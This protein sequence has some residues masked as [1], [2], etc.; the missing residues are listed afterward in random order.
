MNK[1][2]FQTS[3]KVTIADFAILASQ[4]EDEPGTPSADIAPPPD[5]DNFVDLQD[6][7]VL[8]LSWMAVE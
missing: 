1:L 5:G 6:L 3:G 7:Q 2:C 8:A 4:W